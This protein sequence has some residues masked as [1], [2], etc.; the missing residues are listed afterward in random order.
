MEINEIISPLVILFIIGI[1]IVIKPKK[2]IRELA[3]ENKIKLL[4]Y[5]FKFIGI[6]IAILSQI[7]NFSI[8]IWEINIE[9]DYTVLV[10]ILGLLLVA[11]SSE[12]I[13]DELS[14]QIRTNSIFYAFFAGIL[15]HFALVF[16]NY[17]VGGAI[18]E[19]SSMHLTLWMLG[20]YLAT[21]N[22]SKNRL[23]ILNS[24]ED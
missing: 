23:K 12:K 18:K 1:F 16:I 20:I 13:E 24:I 6:G 3:V 19:H 10:L 8:D 21:F 14:R 4:P 2:D 15:A 5:W 7:V 22:S 9:R 11:L 17:W